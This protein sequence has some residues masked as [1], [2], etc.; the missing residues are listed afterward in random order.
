MDEFCCGVGV[1]ECVGTRACRFRAELCTFTCEMRNQH[2]VGG[3]IVAILLAISYIFDE[4][5]NIC[6][7]F[8]FT[9]WQNLFLATVIVTTELSI[10]CISFKN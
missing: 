10:S 1:R 6:E 5:H 4:L 8:I 3:E 7:N 2:C 9:T